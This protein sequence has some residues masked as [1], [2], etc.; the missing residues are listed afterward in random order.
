MFDRAKFESVEPDFLFGIVPYYDFLRTDVLR[1]AFDRN[2]SKLMKLEARAI[3]SFGPSDGIDGKERQFR[4]VYLKII[5]DLQ[6]GL[7]AALV[8]LGHKSV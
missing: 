4:G 8:D 1:S 7:K 3:M 6:M 5:S 2:Y